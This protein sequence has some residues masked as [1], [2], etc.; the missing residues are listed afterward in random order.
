[1][2]GI[3]STFRW[4]HVWHDNSASL[5]PRTPAPFTTSWLSNANQEDIT[6]PYSSSR[7]C[8]APCNYGEPSATEFQ[9]AAA[10]SFHAGWNSARFSSSLSTF[11]FFFSISSPIFSRYAV[12][13]WTSPPYLLIPAM[14]P[15]LILDV[16]VYGLFGL[17]VHSL[18]TQNARVR[19]GSLNEWDPQNPVLLSFLNVLPLFLCDKFLILFSVRASLAESALV[20]LALIW[21]NSVSSKHRR[22]N[23]PFHSWKKRLLVLLLHLLDFGVLILSQQAPSTFLVWATVSMTCQ[24]HPTV[25]SEFLFL[26]KHG[27]FSP[28]SAS[29]TWN[30]IGQLN[31]DTHDEGKY[32]LDRRPVLF[33]STR[34]KRG[35]NGFPC[36]GGQLVTSQSQIKRFSPSP[37]PPLW[38]G[39]RCDCVALEACKYL[40]RILWKTE[41][42]SI[43]GQSCAAYTCCECER[44]NLETNISCRNA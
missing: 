24:I 2:S 5:T 26:S 31:N 8:R 28:V 29:Y 6:N 7:S 23:R 32:V 43:W 10:E 35:L 14:L 16:C 22:E 42:R 9:P 15:L 37:S 30:P 20:L 21:G 11:F 39:R 44:G 36:V 17:I 3:S 33:L 12:L 41:N 13:N 38:L 27:G 18:I 4:K 34:I 1:M 40:R 25:D 19:A